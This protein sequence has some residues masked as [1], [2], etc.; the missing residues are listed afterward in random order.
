MHVL[1]NLSYILSLNCYRQLNYLSKRSH[2]TAVH[3]Q[4]SNS[5]ASKMKS[6]NRVWVSDS[7][8]ASDTEVPSSDVINRRVGVAS[9]KLVGYEARTKRGNKQWVAGGRV[10][11]RTV[12][13]SPGQ[14]TRRRLVSLRGHKFLVDSSGKRLQRLPSSTAL[15][16]TSDVS[17]AASATRL[18][19]R[20]VDRYFVL[21]YCMTHV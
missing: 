6:K 9:L 15:S 21:Y 18:L 20:F 13:K 7:R 3:R 19:A 12:Q 16:S 1:Y 5:K 11:V 8:H 10:N 4:A 2:A 14:H 17:K